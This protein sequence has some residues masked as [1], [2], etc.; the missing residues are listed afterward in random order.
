MSEPPHR[1][2][3]R[4]PER[5]QVHPRQPPQRLAPGRRARD[6]RRHARPQGDRG[7]VGGPRRSRSSTPAATTPPRT[8]PSPATSASRSERPIAGGRRR[9]CSSST[10][11]P[12]RWPTTSRSPR[13]CAAR[14]CRSCWSANKIDDPGRHAAGPGAVPARPGRAA[15][16]SAPLHGLGTGELLDRLVEATG[17]ERPAEGDDEDEAPP[18]VP[19]R[20]R[21][22]SQRRQVVAVQ[23][24]R[25]RA[26]H[27]RQRDRRHDARRHR[28]GASRP[29]HGAFRFID[30]AGMR[31]A[32]KVSGVEYYSY[33]RSVQSLDRAH[34]AVIVVDATLGFGE[35]D[36][37]IAREATR[38]DC[39]TVIA[40]NKTRRRRAPTWRRSPASRGASCA[41]GPQV[42]RRLGQ[43]AASAWRSCST[44]VAS[45]DARYTAHIAT[46]ELNRALKALAARPPAAAEARQAPQDVLHRPV[47]HGA[48]AVRHRG[49]RPH[50]ADARLR[51]LRREP[52]AGPAS[53][54]RACRWS[55]T[56]RAR[57]ERCSTSSPSLVLFVL[58]YLI[59]VDPVRRS[60]SAS[61]ST[62]STCASTAPATSARPTSS[63]CW[64]RR[65][66]SWCWSATCSRGSCRRSSRRTSS[67]RGWRS[68]SPPPGGRSHVLD[69][70]QGRRRQGRRHR[71][72]RRRWR[73]CRWSS[74][75]ILVV[76][77]AAA[78]S[79]R[80][81]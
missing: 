40:V 12:G 14:T 37:S 46:G 45:L 31:K 57:S 24:H 65:P 75:I 72:R 32:A 18:E 5:R 34:V 16:P 64:A 51:L 47:R 71:R 8:R 38:R 49:Q 9:R 54:S 23:R 3:R 21:R 68:S 44:V 59:G 60:S 27:D 1:R 58:A 29:P 15:R 41:S 17:A 78:C 80:A 13:C 76:W 7:R 67:T 43:D 70:P 2:R 39:A 30:T 10:A 36:L 81:T 77:V 4:L 63:A 35:L 25:R 19:G 55:S 66:A 74:S 20:H 69:L 73:W 48:A 26:A 62:A 52:A 6:A 11:A 61:S 56:S 33:L 79:R 53:A 28:H 50:P 42:D 22:A